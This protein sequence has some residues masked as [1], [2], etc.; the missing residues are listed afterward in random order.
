MLFL[1]AAP[2]SAGELIVRIDDGHGKPAGDAVVTAYREGESGVEAHVAAEH[3]AATRII[4]QRDETFLPY[5]EIFRPGDQVV[6]RNSDRTRHHVYSFS[7]AKT[8]EFVIAPGASTPP[9]TLDQ[10]GEISVGCNIHDQM[11]THLFV[12]NAPWIARSTADGNAIIEDL[13]AGTYIVQVWHPQLRPGKPEPRQTL[14]VGE[15][16]VSAA[17]SL[18]LLPDPRQG[19]GDRERSRY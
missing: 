6:F 14:V 10:V 3:A 8:F 5:V 9:V 19:A 2:L 4:D 15:T 1:T 13:P 7:P 11:I 18:A 16:Q 12:S 17:F